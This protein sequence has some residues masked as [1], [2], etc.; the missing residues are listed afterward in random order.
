MSENYNP[1]EELSSEVERAFTFENGDY[2]YVDYD[3]KENI[4]FAGHATNAGIEKEIE[5]QYDKDESLYKNLEK[6][7]Y[8]C[9]DDDPERLK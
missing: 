3:E 4:L 8:A 1:L 2:L 7:Y 5:V 6:L 9:I